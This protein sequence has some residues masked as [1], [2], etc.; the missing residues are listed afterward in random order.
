METD[1]MTK[2][3][4][5]PHGIDWGDLELRL[6]PETVEAYWQD[7]RIATCQT[8]RDRL[9][10]LNRLKEKVRNQKYRHARRQAGASASKNL[11]ELFAEFA[12]TLAPTAQGWTPHPP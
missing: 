7:Y 12:A 2:Y 8:G 1:A 5:L 4:A 9:A 11:N 6:T 3:T 10:A